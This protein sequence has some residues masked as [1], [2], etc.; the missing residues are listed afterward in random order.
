MREP[1][2]NELMHYGIRGQKWGIRRFQ[3]PD[4]TLT[5]AGRRRYGTVENLERGMTLK[6]ANKQEQRRAKTIDK[7]VK[8]ATKGDTKAVMKIQ[9]EL[10]NDDIQ[11]VINRVNLAKRLSDVSDSQVKT[12]M[13]KVQEFTAKVAT[14]SDLV[15]KGTTLYD[16]VAKIANTFGADLPRVDKKSKGAEDLTKEFNL[17]KD[18]AKYAREKELDSYLNKHTKNGKLDLEAIQKDT[19]KFSNEDMKYIFEY[20]RQ[21]QGLENAKNGVTNNRNNGKNSKNNGNENSKQNASNDSGSNLPDYSKPS[22]EKHSDPKPAVDVPNYSKP[23]QEKR[24]ETNPESRRNVQSIHV[25]SLIKD[26]IIKSDYSKS[27]DAVNR[28]ADDVVNR[29]KSKFNQYW[30][31]S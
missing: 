28:L 10:S 15:S 6:Q 31:F 2:P 26:E 21:L 8:A 1:Y 11:S 23:S 7:A 19:K 12:G 4:G 30:G 3:N 27:S 9:K 24:E 5:A 29:G 18:K 25:D 16:N 17:E 14:V 20:N 13:Q 22:Q